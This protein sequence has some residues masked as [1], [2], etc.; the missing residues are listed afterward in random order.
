MESRAVERIGWS[1]WGLVLA[2]LVGV[3]SFMYQPINPQLG[4]RARLRCPCLG[5]SR[6]LHARRPDLLKLEH[7][8]CRGRKLRFAFQLADP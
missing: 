1:Q 8:P 3:S 7:N 5:M 6:P 2:R 4:C